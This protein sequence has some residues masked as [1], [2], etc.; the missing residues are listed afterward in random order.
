MRSLL[1]LRVLRLS[2]RIFRPGGRVLRLVVRVLCRKQQLVFFLEGHIIRDAGS[3]SA[4]SGNEAEPHK[5]SE[6]DS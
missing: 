3:S 6:E 2:E 5:P 1:I 4:P